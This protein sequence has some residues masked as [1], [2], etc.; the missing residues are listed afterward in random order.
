LDFV[1]FWTAVTTNATE[2]NALISK[3]IFIITGLWGTG[4]SSIAKH[5][6]MKPLSGFEFYDFDIGGHMP[7]KSRH[8]HLQWRYR[9]TEYWLQKGKT[10]LGNH[11][12]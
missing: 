1:L 3:R 9:Q 2:S 10:L 6:Q 11:E 12:A 4:K 8:D 7:P 5:F